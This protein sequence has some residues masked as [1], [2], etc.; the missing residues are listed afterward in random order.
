MVP[1]GHWTTTT[2][3]HTIDC[4]GSHAS[5]IANR[6]TNAKVFEAYVD[7]LLAPALRPGD[8]LIMDNLL[9]HKNAAVLE[10]ICET[11]AEVR[12]QPPYSPDLNPIEQI[13]SKIEAHLRRLVVR[14]ER[15]LYNAIGKAIKS[16]TPTDCQHCFRN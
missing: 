1:H 14:A 6:P 2:L 5:M 4:H 15:K 7:W 9:S 8:I 10:K 3:I 11:G 12:L 13:F 16:V